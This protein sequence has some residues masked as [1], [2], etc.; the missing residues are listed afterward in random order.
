MKKRNM[1]SC[2]T[3]NFLSQQNII[4]YFNQ[5]RPKLLYMRSRKYHWLSKVQNSKETI[6]DLSLGLQESY[7]FNKWW[8]RFFLNDFTSTD[9]Y[10]LLSDLKT[11]YTFCRFAS[12]KYHTGILQYSVFCT[13]IISKMCYI[14]RY[15]NGNNIN[16]FY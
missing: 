3:E 2:F 10:K 14:V 16:L 8:L 4:F 13:V 9:E 15:M 11:T 12:F 5:F 6:S 7:N 1:F